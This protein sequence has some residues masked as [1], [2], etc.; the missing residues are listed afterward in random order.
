ML[1]IAAILATSGPAD[2]QIHD[3]AHD[4][5]A[6]EVEEVIFKDPLVRPN[7]APD[8]LWTVDAWAPLEGFVAN[9]GVRIRFGG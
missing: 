8:G 4:G 2:A 3:D 7:R 5:E 9:A 1:A 6:T